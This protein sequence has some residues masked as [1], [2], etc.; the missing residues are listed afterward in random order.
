MGRRITSSLL[1]P[2]PAALALDLALDA[3]GLT[4]RGVARLGGPSGSTLRAWRRGEGGHR[5][6]AFESLG[7]VLRIGRRAAQIVVHTTIRQ[8][9]ER[10]GRSE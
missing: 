9:S 7:R 4:D 10:A 3:A 1:A 8:A 6:D 5:I 2:V